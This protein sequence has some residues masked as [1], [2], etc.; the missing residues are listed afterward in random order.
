MS[1]CEDVLDYILEKKIGCNFASSYIKIS[2]YKET[3]VKDLRKGEETIR[4]GLNYLSQ[5]EKLSKEYK[6]L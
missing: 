6:R 1:D 5:S 3:K 4:T 2:E